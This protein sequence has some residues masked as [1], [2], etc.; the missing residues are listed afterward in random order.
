[1]TVVGTRPKAEG[2]FEM[3]YDRAIAQPYQKAFLEAKEISLWPM[4]DAIRC[5]T[6][7][8]RGAQSD[9]LLHDTAVEMTLRGPKAKLVEVPASATR[10]CSSTSRRCASSRTS[11]RL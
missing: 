4:Y 3:N 2:G 9:I 8:L 11:A 10:R 6:M 5:P 7:V 1:M